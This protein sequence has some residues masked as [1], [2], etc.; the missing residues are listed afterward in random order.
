MKMA[1]S[2]RRAALADTDT[3][4]H[5]ESFALDPA[6]RTLMRGER[7][8]QLRPKSFDVLACLAGHAGHV[9]TKDE[10]L[11]AVWP[12]VVVTEESLS[13]CVSDIRAA[14]GDAD[15]RLVKTVPRRGYVF[16]MPAVAGMSAPIAAMPSRRWPWAAALALAFLLLFAGILW[17]VT[18]PRPAD[19]ALSIA[20][21]PLSSRNGDS[22]QDYLAEAVTEEITVD[23]SRI[24]GALVIGRSTAD[25]YR[26][27]RVDA[28][29]VR[30]ELGVHYVLEGGL[31][32]IGDDVRLSLQLVDAVTG[33]TLWAE[34]FD[35]ELRDLAAL[36]RR[37]TGTVAQSLQ[38]R[39]LEA[40]SEQA[41][42]RP[43]AD[44]QAQDLA[45][46]AWS[47]LHRPRSAANVAAARELLQQAVARDAQS[48]FAW[49]LLANT[50]REDVGG[51]TLNASRAGAT[52]A[53]WL[54]RGERASD[55]AY[56]LDPN[57]P[58]VLDSRAWILA[59]QGRGE[60][61]LPVVQRHLEIDRNNASAWFSL[62]YTLAILGRQEEAIRAC[63]EAIRLSPRDAALK[64]FFVVTAAAHLYLGHD[65]EAL[66]W[67]RKSASVEPT[68]SV[69]HAWVA[70]AAANLGDTETARLALAEFRRLRPDYTIAS[71]RDERLCANALCEQQRQRFY[72]G[73]RRAGLAE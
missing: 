26:G 71:F 31:D 8:V 43:T 5:F 62:C 23:L 28:R 2:A 66:N 20:V 58:A 48:A 63:Q 73:L 70:S 44:L 30:R 34:R 16:A 50:Y 22:Q 41:Q 14:L 9:V 25:S 67:A 10:L 65:A 33:G 57:H 35:G 46:R 69:A 11:S 55:R 15:Q 61:A 38:I 19:P 56:A 21:M 42:R 7:E 51:R 27:R 64:G 37:V 32:R 39:L 12:G 13:R 29:L 36:H 18:R 3:V 53:E 1:D 54:R 60:E 59:L 72:A 45:L 47:L 6:R 49:G 17:W 68:F 4:L 52:R 24:P 40:E